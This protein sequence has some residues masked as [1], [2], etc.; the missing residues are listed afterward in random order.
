MLIDIPQLQTL[1]LPAGQE[2]KLIEP[3]KAF[4]VGQ[5]LKAVVV[6]SVGENK[7][8]LNLDG[9]NINAKS[10]EHFLPGEALKVKVEKQ[11]GQF[12]FRIQN[13][14]LSQEVINQALRQILPKQ[15]TPTNALA[16][17][18]QIIPKLNNNELSLPPALQQQLQSIVKSLPTINQIS[19]GQGLQQAI[20]QSGVFFENQLLQG[21]A[22]SIATHDLK[23]QLLQ[24]NQ[25]LSQSLPS[26]PTTAT[27]ST[28]AALT[29]QNQS[30]EKEIANLLGKN[31]NELAPLKQTQHLDTAS[32]LKQAATVIRA[33]NFYQPAATGTLKSPESLTQ[34]IVKQFAKASLS[35]MLTN[36]TALPPQP[37]SNQGPNTQSPL[38]NH[39][40]TSVPTQANQHPKAAYLKHTSLPLQG[41]F[42]QPIKVPANVANL[43]LQQTR[44]LIEFLKE[45]TTNSLARIQANQLSSLP[46]EATQMPSFLLDLPV[47]IAADKTQVIPIKIEEEANNG[48]DQE[49]SI[50]RLSLALDMEN[51]GPVQLTVSLAANRISVNIWSE[52]AQTKTLFEQNNQQLHQ[53]L[54]E[55]NLQVANIT[56]QQGLQENNIDAK[57]LK[58]L[59]I[60]I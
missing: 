24:L 27:Q 55:E 48:S 39:Q 20:Q 47:N 22:P 33:N 53:A 45:E 59:D 35:P 41:T 43:D 60:E 21:K 58:L 3:S 8:M 44:Q 6:A 23:A 1:R 28:G 56:F 37:K 54:A 9:A 30:V 49:A 14:Q 25:A 42:P 11:D 19:Q 52:Q 17:I 38:A 36:S 18:N 32:R 12:I 51:L 5:I 13:R 15:T 57:T 2:L 16:I 7:L 29:Q 40:Y 50:W 31:A 34:N 10:S 46:R 26:T 4:E